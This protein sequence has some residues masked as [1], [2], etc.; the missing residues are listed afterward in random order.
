MPAHT[1]PIRR[2]LFRLALLGVAAVALSGCGAMDGSAASGL[3]SQVRLVDAS[4]DAGS[5]DF[6]LG[7][8]AL[9]YNL[10]FNT[11]TNYIPTEPGAFKVAM[12]RYG[13]TQTLAETGLPIRTGQH[14]TVVA[15]HVAAGLQLTTLADA[16]APAPEGSASIRLLDQS[17]APGALDVYLVPAGA[18]L[19]NTAPFAAGLNFGSNTGYLNV[20]A[21]TYQVAIL[22][23]GTAVT[24]TTLP[25]FTGPS[26]NYT[27][28]AVSTLIVDNQP[29]PAATPALNVITLSDFPAS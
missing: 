18:R 19:V 27:S 9:A 7:K 23:A 21:G 8:T 13:T 17:T 10:G 28:G 24:A 6:Y 3:A 29:S 2:S 20:P 16:L 14:Y 15:G 11:Y 25:N 5:V 4:P 22:P 26:V 12:N 1:F